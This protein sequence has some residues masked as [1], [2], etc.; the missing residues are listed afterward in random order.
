MIPHMPTFTR[1]GSLM[2]HRKTIGRM[3]NAKSVDAAI[4]IH[5]VSGYTV[6]NWVGVV[7]P[8]VIPIASIALADQQ[9]PS[10]DLSQLSSTGV[11]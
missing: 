3:D 1:L 7:P 2:F 10:T 9:C 4:A 6:I 8:W 5:L 11:H